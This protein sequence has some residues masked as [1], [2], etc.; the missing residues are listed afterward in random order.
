[1]LTDSPQGDLTNDSSGVTLAFPRE[2]R[3]ASYL[4][5][6][7]D[8][9]VEEVT[10]A[11][12]LRRDPLTSRSGRLAHFQGFHLQ[13]ADL[14]EVVLRSR[15][16]CPFCPELVLQATP[17][18]PLAQAVDGRISRGEATLFPNLSPYDRHSVVVVLT[19]QH[20]L[21]PEQF[22]PTQIANGLEALQEYFRALEPTSP[23]SFS[24]VTWNYMPLAGATQIHAHL[25]GFSTDRPGNLLEQEVRSS[26]TFYDRHG[27]RYW[28]RL[29]FCEKKLGE[30]FI[31]EAHHT[32]WLTAFVSKSVVSD[33][34]V[35]F[36]RHRSLE[37]LPA[38][39]IHEFAA[40][41]CAA[42]RSLADDGVV[43]FNLALYPSPAGE[44]DDHFRLHAR[45]SPRI[46]FN[47]AI[48]G[49][50]T[51]AWHHLLEEPFMVRSPEQL[52]T[53]LREPVSSALPDSAGPIAVKQTL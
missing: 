46:Y 30:R 9:A 49:S 1:V 43:S 5:P 12:E 25:Q 39:A 47:P 22:T 24:L 34:L 38:D 36:P 23:G 13:R 32:T 28:D 15:Q 16:G 29:P 33:L 11:V 2:L 42:L 41:L 27:Q 3:T 45:L 51:T 48:L 53:L 14:S 35:I 19:E 40:G 20:F 8:G 4:V 17:L 52:A 6:N 21:S 26:R 7:S 44:S 31:A 18:L 10:M 50:D 37:E